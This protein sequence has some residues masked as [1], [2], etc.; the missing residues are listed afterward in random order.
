M[1]GAG[2]SLH[3]VG[4][5]RP[6]FP[7]AGLGAH[8]IGDCPRGERIADRTELADTIGHSA[9]PVQPREASVPALPCQRNQDVNELRLR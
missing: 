7:Q 8:R 5:D 9:G 6:H 4:D 2:V 1:N 3:G